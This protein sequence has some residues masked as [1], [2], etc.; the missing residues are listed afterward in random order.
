MDELGVEIEIE[1]ARLVRLCARLTGDPDSA[2][3]LAQEALLVAWRNSHKLHGEESRSRWLAGIARNVCLHWARSRGR[4]LRRLVYPGA[5]SGELAMEERLSDDFDL[6]LELERDELA[7]LLDRALAQLPPDT[8]RALIEHYIHESPRAE[9]AVRLGLSDDALEARLRRGKLALKRLIV[10]QLSEE[11]VSFG[12]VSPG[13]AGWQETR[14][15]CPDCGERKLVGRF[16]ERRNLQ[17]DCVGCRGL[18]RVVQVRGRTGEL[19]WGMPSTQLLEGVNGFKAALNRMSARNYEFYEHGI[20]GRTARCRWCGSD[21]PLR[22]SPYE[23]FGYRDVLT[24][25]LHCGQQGAVGTTGAV[26][27]HTPQAQAFWRKHGR[28]RTLPGQEVESAGAPA[29]VSTIES[30]TGSAKLQVVLSRDTLRV[31]DIQ[32]VRKV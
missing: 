25:C 22:V 18:P 11:A 10:T 28:I 30:V 29:T 5:S 6:E 19:I 20:A 27:L 12:L 4:E 14:I 2:E 21:A 7:D 17:L 32:S 31:I 8:G 23:E 26:A 9:V 24:D 15:W 13:D 3:D 1:R 16:T